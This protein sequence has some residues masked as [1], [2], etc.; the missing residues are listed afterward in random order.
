MV[1]R[2]SITFDEVTTPIREP[3]TKFG[4]QPVWINRPTWPLSRETGRPMRFICQIALDPLIFGTI[5]TRMAYLFITDEQEFVDATYEPDGGE[6]AVVLQPDE[7]AG[8]IFGQV[9]GPT[10]YRMVERPGLDRL[11]AET[12]EF[13]VTL[14]IGEDVEPEDGFANK[15]GGTP[16]F[17]QNE[18]YPQGGPWRLLLQLDSGSVPFSINFGDAGVGYAFISED[19]TIGKFLWQCC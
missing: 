15:I 12:C 3:A 9:E 10:L 7:S 6:N 11:V 18:E 19:G 8:P 2:C 16:N 4:G 1:P 5:P 13:A 14:D 17:L